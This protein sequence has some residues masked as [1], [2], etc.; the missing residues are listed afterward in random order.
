[1]PFVKSLGGTNGTYAALGNLQ[2]Q[3]APATTVQQN[4]ATTT[5]VKS[6]P[7]TTSTASGG[8]LSALKSI[9]QVSTS[10]IVPTVAGDMKVVPLMKDAVVSAA[11]AGV[12][13]VKIGTGK[14]VVLPSF[15]SK[16]SLPVVIPLENF[17]KSVWQPL[18]LEGITGMSPYK[19]EILAL[20][21]FVPLFDDEGKPTDASTYLQTRKFVSDL[22]VYN[23]MTA[24]RTASSKVDLL[25]QP[26]GKSSS[27]T[28]GA[29]GFL[30][31]A[32]PIALSVKDEKLDNLTAAVENLRT[33]VDFLVSV[34]DM[35][36]SLKSRLDLRDPLQTVSQDDSLIHL[37]H[38]SSGPIQ[39]AG[40]NQAWLS[41]TRLGQTVLPDKVSIVDFLSLCGFDKK[42]MVKWSSSRLWTQLVHEVGRQVVGSG[43]NT[44]QTI[45]SNKT[46]YK[47]DSNQF[48][49]NVA[50]PIASPV[51][52][53]LQQC[54]LK[55]YSSAAVPL[56]IAETNGPGYMCLAA[57]YAYDFLDTAV[58]FS[59]DPSSRI[60]VLLD[61][62]T[63]D[64][65]YSGMLL[66]KAAVQVLSGKFGAQIPDINTWNG[67]L[68]TLPKVFGVLSPDVL[69]APSQTYSVPGL[70]LKTVLEDGV[71]KT[72]ALFE[73]VQLE[74]AEGNTSIT[75]GGEFYVD[76]IFDLDGSTFNVSKL[77]TLNADVTAMLNNLLVLFKDGNVLALPDDSTGAPIQNQSLFIRSIVEELASSTTNA[78]NERYSVASA[79]AV[80]KQASDVGLSG[81]DSIFPSSPGYSLEQKTL[82]APPDAESGDPP[83]EENTLLTQF[84]ND[85]KSK[86]VSVRS[87]A[88]LAFA[89]KS[90]VVKSAL[91]TVF[92]SYVAMNTVAVA[93]TEKSAAQQA[94]VDVCDQMAKQ[95]VDWVL[96]SG[97]VSE[98]KM[99]DIPS[100]VL[101]LSVSNLVNTFRELMSEGSFSRFVIDIMSSSLKKL[102]TV[103]FTLV[104]GLASTPSYASIGQWEDV[105]QQASAAFKSKTVYGGASD[106][107]W[108]AGLFDV[109][110]CVADQ[111]SEV[112]V[113]GKYKDTTS[114]SS[115][116][117]VAV[118]G[119][120]DGIALRVKTV[121]VSASRMH[122]YSAVDKEL[123]TL[124]VASLSL[125]GSLNDVQHKVKALLD[126]VTQPPGEKVMAGIVD[127]VGDARLVQ[128]VVQGSQTR[129]LYRS[130]KDLTARLANV[131]E[132]DLKGESND[133]DE[134]EDVLL[135]DCIL[136]AD[137]YNMLQ[138][139]FGMKD[140]RQGPGFNKRILSVGLPTGLAQNL[141]QR[142]D[143]SKNMKKPVDLGARQVDIVR[144]N[145]YKVDLDYPDLVFKPISFPFELS[146]FV[147]RFDKD[148]K[149][150][151]PKATFKDVALSLPLI[152]LG[153]NT[154]RDAPLRF[155]LEGF[156]GPS[157]DFLSE[158]HKYEILINH[159]MSHLIELY[160]RLMCGVDV[161]ERKFHV[162]PPP[163]FMDPDTFGKFIDAGVSI[164]G[165]PKS[166][167]SGLQAS[168]GLRNMFTS[169]DPKPVKNSQFAAP[170]VKSV[171][172][173]AAGL[174]T[175]S[176]EFL[177]Q[178]ISSTTGAL[179]VATRYSSS[180]SIVKGMIIPKKFDRVFNVIVD[181]DDF[182]I[183][184]PMTWSS[185]SG[186]SMFTSLHTAGIV[187]D[188]SPKTM[189]AVGS[190]A[191]M[192]T[193]QPATTPVYKILPRQKSEGDYT[194]EKYFVTVDTF[195]DE[196]L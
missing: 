162:T 72:V 62:L 85:Q 3:A 139:A 164:A 133:P 64:Y 10:F 136:S 155:G 187:F 131:R 59:S 194:F 193:L 8:A 109:M 21:Y 165:S 46:K 189:S 196:V 177:A 66:S 135:D 13:L 137:Q 49:A 100:S 185:E 141:K 130:L 89:R 23:S 127:A 90:S 157:Y 176:Q 53:T 74:N 37:F 144:I 30:S 11:K 124:R 161:D 43:I 102:Q 120:G 166:A 117:T 51:M 143:L 170:S 36:E 31:V 125:L 147:S 78:I 118:W 154:W 134:L 55:D 132:F 145:V 25:F 75:S 186:K 111:F 50:V 115:D 84:G 18:V 158:Q 14:S 93:D 152:D 26:S 61:A 60:S 146:K 99:S 16:N 56:K 123:S 171:G 112:V 151:P 160:I 169:V 67:G 40:T 142:I 65:R 54:S 76:S 68:P 192:T 24:L 9:P 190:M 181:P 122:V 95:I 191:S 5:V 79:L 119:G 174:S 83:T 7:S 150:L 175:A 15:S 168:T 92:M 35:A 153:D 140:F 80:E 81:V 41:T 94:M 28:T 104:N 87:L 182:V 116:G 70:G 2:V 52:T 6:A 183:D 69:A 20:T 91:F 12:P 77:K 71:E 108:L 58:K 121:D 45:Q 114:V 17:S 129:L 29:K 97:G 63:K 180:D 167:P 98:V 44:E 128:S 38:H 4:A 179:S 73:P 126:Q 96:G 86:V 47:S 163:K 19:P 33:Q 184:H 106:V 32:S 110:C 113:A 82:E 42:L 173:D 107:A 195:V 88:L 188:A 138:A 48:V 34:H 101:T 103:S 159:I 149:K 27:P 148:Y 156:S 172:I 39:P 1:M 105:T 57:I 178:F 22:T